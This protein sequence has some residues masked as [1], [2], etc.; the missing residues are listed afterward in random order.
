MAHGF[1]RMPIQLE[2]AAG[3]GEVGGDGQFFAGAEAKQGADRRSGSQNG[4]RRVREA[5]QSA[6]AAPSPADLA[7]RLNSAVTATS[8]T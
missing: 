3:D 2:V 7:S 5:L 8:P 6:E 1:R 4:S